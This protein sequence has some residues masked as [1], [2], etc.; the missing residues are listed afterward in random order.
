[1]RDV[2]LVERDVAPGAATPGSPEPT[3]RSLRPPLAPTGPDALRDRLDRRPARDR[4]ARGAMAAVLL[5]L[6]AVGAV[7]GTEVRQRARADRLAEVP[8]VAAPIDGPVAVLWRMPGTPLAAPRWVDGTVIGVVRAPSGGVDV[9][10]LAAATGAE[11]WRTPVSPPGQG[12]DPSARCEVPGPSTGA[13]RSGAGARDGRVLACVVVEDTDTA[14]AAGIGSATYPTRTR[15][16]LL[17]AATG[18]V[19][20]DRAVPATTSATVLGPDLLLAH[21]EDDGHVRL[22]RVD[23]P[24]G[25]EQWSFRSPDPVPADDL[26]Q[27]RLTVEADH[28]LVL[29]DAGPVWVMTADGDPV[30]SWPAPPRSG[31]DA[32]VTQLLTGRGA[33]VRLTTGPIGR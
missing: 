5:V 6:V 31:R 33:V 19:R 17:D 24:D 16:V 4:A 14:D 10:G 3:G 28:E 15:L 30:R 13:A 21:V 29:L 2:E 22:A 9:L 18:V 11:V 8:G 12:S 27:R 23:L 25:V 1:M 20:S 32:P 7:L 26:G